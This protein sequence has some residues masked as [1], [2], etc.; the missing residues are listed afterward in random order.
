MIRRPP[1]STR[2]DSLFPFTTLFL[3][4]KARAQLLAAIRAFF[5]ERDV[6]EVSTPVLSRHATVDRHI[7]SFVVSLPNH[8]SSITN[9]GFLQTSPEFAM[10][11]LLAAGSGPIW[12]KIGRAHVLTPV[13]NAQLV[14]RLLL[15]K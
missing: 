2:T 9:P 7:E 14:C 10:K 1:R 4:L 6:L 15:E 3:S 13:T 5:V 12:Q 11:R 8:E